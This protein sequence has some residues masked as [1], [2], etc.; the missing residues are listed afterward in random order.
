[1]GKNELLSPLAKV[2]NGSETASLVFSNVA[3]L[4]R[5]S[6]ALGGRYRAEEE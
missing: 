4:L 3:R 6:Y 5:P 2:E 1:M